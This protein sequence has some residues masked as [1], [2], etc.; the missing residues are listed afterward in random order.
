MLTFLYG[1]FP[2]KTC[3]FFITDK[4]SP[5]SMGNK[6]SNLTLKVNVEKI[7]FFISFYSITWKCSL[8]TRN[9][10]NLKF[11]PWSI[12]GYALF[13]GLFHNVKVF[14][15]I[16]TLHTY[17][18][19]TWYVYE[20]LLNLYSTNALKYFFRPPINVGREREATPKSFL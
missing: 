11:S 1:F 5:F 4:C 15:R 9:K 16:L 6:I 20:D 3:H 12:Y 10:F 2:K 19:T 8:K 18:N 7:I 14:L 13:F 17:M